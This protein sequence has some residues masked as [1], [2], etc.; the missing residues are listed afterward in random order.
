M[1]LLSI[2]FFAFAVSADGFMVG[3]A[4][5]IKNIRIPLISLLVIAFA[6]SLAVSI[7]MI[8]GNGLAAVLPDSW[9]SSTGALILIIMGAVFLLNACREK[10]NTLE[11]N[12]EDPL[13][14]FNI[15]SMGIIIQIL[16]E[17]SAADFDC[18]GEINAGEAFFLGFAL[19]VD[20]LGAG[21]GLALAGFN[22]F[23][24]AI[25]VGVLKFILVSIGISLGNIL[26][27]KKLKSFAS[28][29]PGTIFIVLGIVE[30]I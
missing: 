25:S 28:L 20:A 24:T 9:A 13:V 7:S 5:G 16:K 10:I 4:Y 21:I 14:S 30:F 22:I 3:I 8:C 11:S 1:E 29:I 17:P 27:N 12:G 26:N 23:F 19:A 2:F 15:K 18:S 6:S